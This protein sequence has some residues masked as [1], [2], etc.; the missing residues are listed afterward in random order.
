MAEHEPTDT[1]SKKVEARGARVDREEQTTHGTPSQPDSARTTSDATAAASE[2]M[3]L[4]RLPDSANRQT[5]R[6]RQRTGDPPAT[7]PT[8]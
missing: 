5:P 6:G 7:K 1:T 4:Q 2:P 3:E 8:Q